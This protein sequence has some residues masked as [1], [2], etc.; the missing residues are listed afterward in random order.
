MED[1]GDVGLSIKTF[2]SKVNKFCHQMNRMVI[3]VNNTL[4]YN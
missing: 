2:R 4:L 1:M 3:A